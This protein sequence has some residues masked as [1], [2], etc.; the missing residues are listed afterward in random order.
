MSVS[1]P[2]NSTLI[3]PSDIGEFTMSDDFINASPATVRDLES[4]FFGYCAT[5]RATRDTGE[6]HAVQDQMDFFSN[7]GSLAA[8][9]YL[10]FLVKVADDAGNL[11]TRSAFLSTNLRAKIHSPDPYWKDT[12]A[13]GGHTDLEDPYA[14]LGIRY[15]TSNH[16]PTVITDIP[17]HVPGR[18]ARM[19]LG[20]THHRRPAIHANEA[21][22]RVLVTVDL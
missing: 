7:H 19:P 2:E 22:P 4:L 8:E 14:V 1:T 13:G 21:S 5:F 3:P 15:I 18:V 6:Y 20:R 9:I 10:S 12:R 16:T 11:A 17:T